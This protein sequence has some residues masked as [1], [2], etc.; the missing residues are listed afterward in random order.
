MDLSFGARLRAQRERRQVSL[1]TIAERTKIKQSLLE[2]LERDDVS[3]WPSGIFRR[4]YMRAYASAIGLDPEAAVREFLDLHPDPL[5]DFSTALSDSGAHGDSHK[6]GTRLRYLIGSAMATFPSLRGQ[7]PKGSPPAA[8]V[9]PPDAEA[10]IVGPARRLA[11]DPGPFEANRPVLELPIR[12]AEPELKADASRA[13]PA[14]RP[15]ARAA[16]RPRVDFGSLAQVCTQLGRASDTRDVSPA[17]EEAVRI[18]DAA[19]IILW[20]WDPRAG[21]TIPVLAHGYSEEVLGQL[22]HVPPDSDN[23]IAAAY[24]SADVCIVSG[25]DGATGAIVVPLVTP[26][27]CAGVL[28]LELRGGAE[29]DE[30]VRAFAMILSAQLASLVASPPMAHAVSA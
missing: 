5:E 9:V 6:G 16:S 2:A 3:H 11:P 15:R 4:S 17:L 29:Q 25:S 12:M 7:H 1:A 19:G 20:M 8:E 30:D 14:E 27:G 18:L 26:G 13:V 21:A 22:P 28:A 24:R 23:A 10:V